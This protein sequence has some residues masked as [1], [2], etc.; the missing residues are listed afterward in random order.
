MAKTN[1][2]AD[3]IEVPIGRSDAPPPAMSSGKWVTSLAEVSA[4]FSRWLEDRVEDERIWT[5]FDRFVREILLDL[6]GATRVRLFRTVDGGRALRPL[7]QESGSGSSSDAFVPTGLTEHVLATG[8]RYIRG[9]WSHGALVDQLAA[10]SEEPGNGGRKKDATH[11]PQKDCGG[12]SSVAAGPQSESRDP[13]LAVSP[14]E[15]GPVAWMFAIRSRGGPAPRVGGS[16]GSHSVGLVVVGEVLAQNLASRDG[17]EALANLINGFWLHV[18]DFECLQL[19]RRTDRASGV[20]N[21]ADFLEAAET[22]ATEAEQEGEPVVVMAVAMEGLRRLDDDG[23]WA[24]RD[25]LIQETGRVLRRKLRNGDIVGRF[26]DDRFVVLL[27][28]L[29]LALGRL[30]AGKVIQS[31]REVVAGV[32]QE[33]FPEGG[34]DYV[35]VR[36]GLVSSRGTDSARQA[37]PSREGGGVRAGA[38]DGAP[39]PMTP[40]PTLN[41]LLT[42]ALS[43]SAMARRNGREICIAGAGPEPQDPRA[44]SR[45]SAVPEAPP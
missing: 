43:A 45:E 39:D 12:R 13:Q 37:A 9:D 26:S 5:A 7:A 36:C 22:T 33:A 40:P 16:A 14:P 42:R 27:R 15:L 29:D 6:I 25:R 20:L 30:I 2:V 18:R 1:G 3:V 19:A 8:R 32:M 23:Y 17:F 34:K 44:A 41:D 31:I 10:E 4:S 11:L 21:R 28:W 24:V 38:D 35:R